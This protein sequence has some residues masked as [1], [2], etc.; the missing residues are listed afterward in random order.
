MSLHTKT[1]EELHELLVNKELTVEE[2]VNSTFDYIETVEPTI[3]AFIS[4][5][6]EHALAEAKAVD[7]RGVDPN[8][9]FDGI[10]VAI[11]DNIVTKNGKTTAA[12]KM[13][14]DFSSVYDATVVE[15]LKD[16]GMIA[17]GKTNLDEFAMGGTTETSKLQSTVNP[18]DTKKVPGGSSGG[19]AAAVSAGM[20]PVSLGTDTGGSI[21]QPAAYTNL[22]GI[23]PTYGT[24]S[25][26]GVIAFAS[27]LDQVGP[28]TRTVKDNALMLNLL[29]GLD[30]KDGTSA[31]LSIDYSEKIGKEIKGL[32]IGLPKEFFQADGLNKDV[33]KKVEVAVEKLKE[34]GAE[35]VEVSIPNFKYSVPTYYIVA[36]SEASSN[37][38][39]FDGIRYGYSAEDAK[40]LEELYVK[41]RSEGFGEEV[42]RRII[43]GSLSLGVDYFDELFGK[44]TKVRTLLRNELKNALKYPDVL[45]PPTTM[46][47]TPF[48][49]S[50]D[51]KDPTEEYLSDILT[52]T[53]N[54]TGAPGLNIPVGF[55]DG[56]PVG[57]QLIGNYFDE[58]TLYQI[59]YAYEQATDHHRKYPNIEGGANE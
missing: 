35:I 55:V 47:T 31:D 12:S 14:E 21:R 49:D 57:M 50:T 41:T 32:R 43:I 24:I 27:S 11:K 38:Q 46:K 16:A 4:L 54:L 30:E 29:S 33:L 52:V 19:S 48:L 36:S 18:W 2:L 5:D 7:A 20:V 59:A 26:Y 25:R 17:V 39:R 45:L 37:L 1:I 58:P 15:K 34:L 44:A 51:E 42:K 40:T 8:N 10:P 6:K 23:K 13:L 53:V 28:L 3:G 22:V 9:V 56:M